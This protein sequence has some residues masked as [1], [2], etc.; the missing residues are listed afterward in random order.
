MQCNTHPHLDTPSTPSC[1]TPPIRRLCHL[2]LPVSQFRVLPKTVFS[3]HVKQT[4]SIDEINP[5]NHAEVDG[6]GFSYAVAV[7]V[8]LGGQP[9]S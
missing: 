3:C 8:A 2:S 7:A 5:P 6:G 4:R 1:T 9:A